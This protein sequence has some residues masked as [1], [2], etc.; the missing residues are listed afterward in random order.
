MRARCF[1]LLT[2]V[3]FK[4]N[5]GTYLCVKKYAVNIVR[6]DENCECVSNKR[7]S[8]RSL[9]GSLV[10]GVFYFL[11]HSPLKVTSLQVI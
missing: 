10:S 2:I 9:A 1:K 4:A 3:E 8:H 11:D 5:I 6:D 7:T